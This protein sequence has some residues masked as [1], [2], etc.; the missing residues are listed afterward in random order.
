MIFVAVGTQKF[1][2][3][4]LLKKVD[5]LIECGEITEEVF[6]Q[7]GNSD[8]L[9]QHYEYKAF[10]DKDEFASHISS[11]DTV[12]THS[13]VATI[14]ESIKQNKP[15]IVVPRLA[16]YGEHVDDHQL[17]IAESFERLNFVF[18]Y[19][20]DKNLAQMIREVK[21]H[22]FDKYVSQKEKM[23]DEIEGYLRSV[24]TDGDMKID[25]ITLHRVRNYGSSLQ[26]LATQ[27]YFQ[28]LGCDVEVIDYYPERYSSFGLL[29]RLKY[30]SKKLEKNPI[31]LLCA[32][33]IISVSYLK[34]KIVFDSFLKKY[35]HMTPKT[36]KTEEELMKNCPAADAYCTGSDQVWNSHWNEGVDRPL[37][38]SFVGADKYKFSYAA[39]I[40]DA[41][42][43]N[44]E[45][46]QVLPML[47]EY[48]RIS[49]REDVGV[50]IIRDMGLD[51][52]HV[53]DPTL[54]FK[55]DEWKD[56]I[57]DRFKGQ[58]Y[59]V[60]YNLHHDKRIDQYA[61]Q[62]AKKHGL[63][64]YNISYNFHDII[65]K[66]TLKWCPTVEEYLGLI[67]NAQ[68]TITDSF[69]ATVFSILFHTKF[70]IIYPE[71][72]SSRLRSILK[73]VN[74]QERGF[75]DM[76][77]LESAEKEIDFAAADRVLENERKRT[78]KYLS[79]IVNEVKAHGERR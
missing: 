67:N 17:Q 1:S 12:I 6:C 50:S 48:E 61:N 31:L 70:V 63:K 34:K 42:L 69:H 22:R 41:K 8:Y 28:K 14:I 72:A 55:K 45:K 27:R 73:L 16:K 79:G 33:M 75:D 38:L 74:M 60:T 35:I 30:K 3:N 7:I 71:E 43:G 26:T 11:A 65:R 37:Y 13:G 62:L 59:V 10:L 53:L 64:V 54:L 57:S 4:R 36:Y 77:K 2:F 51:A 25:V 9:P 21:L 18:M 78:E 68:F 58:K 47:Q 32:R 24:N 56:Y 39:S 29:K 76:P 40:G 15:V 23:I 66:G 49:V 44:Q 19:T 5:E 20:E 46:Q 52:E